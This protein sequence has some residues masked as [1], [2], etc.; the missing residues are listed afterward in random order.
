M[1]IPLLVSLLLVAPACKDKKADGGESSTSTVGKVADG[2]SNLAK[3]REPTG[4][5]HPQSK[6]TVSVDGKPVTM[7]TALAWKRNGQVRITASSVPVGCDEVTGDMRRLHDGEVT[8]DV[9]V[10]DALAPDGTYKPTLQE[11][12]FEGNT[13]VQMRQAI[14]ATGD[15]TPGQPVTAEVA[16]TAESAGG[17]KS[18]IDVKGTIDALGCAVAPSKDPPPPLPPEMPATIEIAGKKLP[19]RFAKL[20]ISRDWPSLDLYTGGEACKQVPF[21]QDSELHV[22]LTWFDKAKPDVSQIAISGS[23]LNDAADQTF[24]KKK[25]TVTPMP[26]APGELE[27]KGD[28]TVNGYPVKLDGKVTAVVCPK[29]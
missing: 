11:T 27:I 29:T 7:A 5:P 14:A 13:R 17:K 25:L 20:D 21:A 22:S 3:D 2:I 12:Y 19:I 16:F 18:T 26:L 28:V 24:D 1:R 8:F 9:T 6:L 23:I 4:T 15:G 10:A